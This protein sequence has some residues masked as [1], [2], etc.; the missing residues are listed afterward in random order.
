MGRK[1]FGLILAVFAVLLQFEYI[2]PT[3]DQRGYEAF[4]QAIFGEHSSQ[5]KSFFPF[6]RLLVI[7]SLFISGLLAIHPYK[8]YNYFGAKIGLAALLYYTIVN[9]N[10]FMPTDDEGESMLRWNLLVNFLPVMGTL[11][12]IVAERRP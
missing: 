1:G 3:D 7:L 5:L 6:Q 4:W 9:V 10:P 11:L 12:V 8:A 2:K